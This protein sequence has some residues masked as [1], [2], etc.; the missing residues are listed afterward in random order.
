MR[1]ARLELNGARALVTGASSGIGRA[2]ARELGR[3][4]ARLVL[5]AR[6]EAALREAAGEIEVEVGLKPSTIAVD[7]A[8]T[9][10]AERLAAVATT[11]LGGIDLLVNNA[12]LG[13]AATEW[14]P[15]A[16]LLVRQV[17]ETNYF[18]PLTLIG[19]LLPAMRT[20]R[21]GCIVNV[22]SV[23]ALSPAPLVGQ[24]NASKAALAMATETLQL[25]LRGSGVGVVHVIPGATATR[26]LD[27]LRAVPGGKTLDRLLP[28][29]APETLARKI[30][31]AIE[32]GRPRVLYPRS[33]AIVRLLPTLTAR[34][35]AVL[36]SRVDAPR[37]PLHA[38]RT[39][40]LR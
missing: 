1:T 27:D 37:A 32:R 4:G 15:Q 3:R 12:G 38:G 16:A 33:L 34:L 35:S 30:A 13:I 36:T 5:A 40:S 21:C 29:A 20:R 17:F 2:L 8:R 18:S 14:D 11:A 28:H 26:M 6:R 19:A 7:L 31:I 22:S 24:Y 23:G 39:S 25:E 9:G 10:E